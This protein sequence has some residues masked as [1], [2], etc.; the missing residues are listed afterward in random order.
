MVVPDAAGEKLEWRT[1]LGSDGSSGPF[2]AV[3]QVE[4]LRLRVLIRVVDFG[5]LWL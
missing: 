2:E 4:K 5:G 3:V 1:I